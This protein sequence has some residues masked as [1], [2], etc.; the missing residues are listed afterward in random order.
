L[1]S[2][3][4]T[5]KKSNLVF[6]GLSL[7]GNEPITEYVNKITTTTVTPLAIALCYTVKCR[8]I[9]CSALD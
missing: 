7:T 2:V 1:G 3:G 8:R 9:L 4:V 6:R 5:I